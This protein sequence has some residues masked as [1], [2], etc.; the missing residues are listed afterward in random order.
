MSYRS[1]S[2][3]ARQKDRV[4]VNAWLYAVRFAASPFFRA[5]DHLSTAVTSASKRAS[6][7][8]ADQVLS[9]LALR[10]NAVANSSADMPGLAANFA[11][12]WSYCRPSDHTNS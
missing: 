2:T 9:A 6:T 1:L 12:T 3:G 5:T 11:R 8:T 10:L 4:A 7:A